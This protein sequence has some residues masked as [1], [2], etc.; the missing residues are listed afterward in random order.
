[1]SIAFDAF[2]DG[3]FS[4]GGTSTW[5]HNNSGN[6]IGVLAQSAV[7]GGASG[8]TGITYNGV[9]L[10]KLFGMVNPD[11][12]GSDYFWFWYLENAPTG[13]H[14]VVMSYTSA[15]AAGI[16]GSY[17]GVAT[18]SSI[19]ASQNAHNGTGATVTATMTAGA[20]N[21]WI[22][23]LIATP[24]ATSAAQPT[25]NGTARGV[26][27]DIGYDWLFDRGPLSSGSVNINGTG[28]GAANSIIILAALLKVAAT[29]QIK[30]ISTVVQ[31]SIKS[32]CGV[33][34]ASIKSVSGVT[35]V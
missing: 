32:I 31:A 33:V 10:T 6:W 26:E 28:T 4:V 3:L 1:M 12:V 8:I 34:N 22:V 9:A 15:Y 20:A 24:G 30:S 7:A 13:T 35:N 16:S 19:D 2:V 29:T 18:T 11:Q 14:N 23:A 27:N 21:E 17:S 25:S 5:S